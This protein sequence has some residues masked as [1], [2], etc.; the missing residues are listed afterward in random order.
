VSNVLVGY[1]QYNM[2]NGQTSE[3]E[4]SPK[5]TNCTEH[6]PEPKMNQPTTS[7]L[8][9]D[10]RRRPLVMPNLVVNNANHALAGKIHQKN[11]AYVT[12]IRPNENLGLE[13]FC[14]QPNAGP[15]E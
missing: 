2:E 11:V 8:Y 14:Y 12:K 5:Y 13:R 6:G 9:N 15:K 1:G 4:R 10:P 7:I 3:R